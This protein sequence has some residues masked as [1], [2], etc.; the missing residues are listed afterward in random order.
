[1]LESWWC[2]MLSHV[3]RSLLH[4]KEAISFLFCFLTGQIFYFFGEKYCDFIWGY[5]FFFDL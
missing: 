3:H 5:I 1:M 2:E 4:L